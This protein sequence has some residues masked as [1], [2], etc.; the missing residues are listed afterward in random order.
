MSEHAHKE[1]VADPD[2]VRDRLDEIRSDAPDLRL[3]EVDM[4]PKRYEQAHVPGAVGVDWEADIAGELG[5]DLVGKEAFESL[6]S[7]C[8]ITED[9]TVILYGD[10]A[11]WFAAHAYWVFTYYGHDDVRLMDG[12]RHYWEWNDYPT[13]DEVP[14]FTE[15]EYAADEPDE[16]VRAYAEDVEEAIETDRVLVDT[17]NPREYRGDGPPADIP[18]TTE[19]EGH[20]PGAENI[21]W[22]NAVN[23]DGTFK[24][25]AELRE[26]YDVPADGEVITYCRIGERSSIT[27]F[28]YEELLGRDAANYD[29]SWT[30]WSNR[31][32][33]P[34]ERGTPDR[35]AGRSGGGGD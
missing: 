3:L 31:E 35:P 6:A 21:P 23:A 19:R 32:G 18:D 28:V 33:A 8:G 9:T 10:R 27:W 14:E 17:R 5:R 15:R 16:S 7:R 22:G 30:E 29:G 11:N 24:S 34:V 20:I 1:A 12:G 13:T 2:R 25:E 26:V 4:E